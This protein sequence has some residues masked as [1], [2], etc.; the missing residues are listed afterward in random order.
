MNNINKIK[1]KIYCLEKLQ[2]DVKK[3]KKKGEKIVFTNGCFDIL[4]KGHVEILAKSADLGNKIIVGVN[5][6][7]SV[8]N[9]KGID[10]PIVNEHSRTMLLASLSIVDAV[11]LFD[12]ETPIN[13]IKIIKPDILTKGGDYSFD[14]VVGNN[15]VNEE[16]GKTALIPLV[17]GYSS[18]QIIEKIKKLK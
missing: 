15:F 10:R 13:L 17:Q 6:D 1:S 8:K 18:T 7:K 3:W 16:G 14:T 12:E 2:D 4:H 11:I 9:L 5:S